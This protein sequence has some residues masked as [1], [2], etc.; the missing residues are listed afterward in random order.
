M[1]GELRCFGRIRGSLCIMGVLGLILVGTSGCQSPGPE[2]GGTAPVETTVASTPETSAAAAETAPVAKPKRAT[3]K[4]KRPP[5]P[6]ISLDT[7]LYDFG[8]MKPVVKH[9]AKFQI[10]NT[11]GKPLRITKIGKCCGAIIELGGKTQVPGKDTVI[12]PGKKTVLKATYKPTAPGNYKKD[13]EVYS[14]DPN[15]PRVRLIVQGKVIKTFDAQPRNLRL[16]LNK[17]NAGC[18]PL[19]IKALDDQAFRIKE[20]Q[21]TGDA[22]RLD[23]DPNHQALTHVLKPVVDM[24]ALQKLDP[25]SG[26]IKID[27]DRPDYNQIL[28]H[29]QLIKPF[30]ANP[31]QIFL[32]KADPAKKEIRSVS[33]LDNYATGG[34]SNDVSVE[35]E[36]ITSDGSGVVK[37]L[38][39]DRVH[40]GYR[41]KLEIT[42]PALEP[43]KTSFNEQLKIKLKSGEELKVNLRGFYSQ[44]VMMKARQEAEEA[45]SA[46]ATAQKKPEKQGP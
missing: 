27:L 33:V 31:P 32:F 20:Y 41:L 3:K 23:F 35:I 40:D 9:T 6:V 5:H 17:E 1:A 24:N 10:T 18:R 16:F 15:T 7:V 19:E 22:I 30:V 28:I 25:P 36:S 42:P 21:C 12:K 14:N 39:Q 44:A 37:V 26:R 46:A 8:E 4:A 43:G 34:D 11:G 45:A 2:T 13:L 29:F 38:S